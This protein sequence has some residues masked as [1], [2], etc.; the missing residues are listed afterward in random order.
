MIT[1]VWE[2]REWVF[3]GIGILLITVTMTIIKKGCHVVNMKRKEKQADKQGKGARHEE[4]YGETYEMRISGGNNNTQIGT[5]GTLN[6]IN[7]P[8]EDKS[9]ILARAMEKAIHDAEFGIRHIEENYIKT[10]NYREAEKQLEENNILILTGYP[11]MGKTEMAFALLYKFRYQFTIFSLEGVDE[12][13]EYLKIAD[14]KEELFFIDDLLGQ[15]IYRDSAEKTKRLREVIDNVLKSGGKKKLILTV[16]ETILKDF[17]QQNA[18]IKKLLD[19]NGVPMID[20]NFH[21]GE[22]KVDYISESMKR[23]KTGT[24]LKLDKEKVEFLCEKES[25]KTI[26]ESICFTP[27]AVNRLLRPQK[28]ISL[29]KYKKQFQSYMT[30][31]DFIWKKELD[32]LGEYCRL[33]LYIIY[34]LTDK[35]V[36][37]EIADRCF[38]ALIEED[39]NC[40]FSTQEAVESMNG[41]LINVQNEKGIQSIGLFH[42]TLNEY[43][44]EHIP[45]NLALRIVEHACYLDQLNRLE[46]FAKE[47]I[48]KKL[49][50]PHEFFTYGLVADEE[51]TF[52]AMMQETKPIIYG[53]YLLKYNIRDKGL[54]DIIIKIAKCMLQGNYFSLMKHEDIVVS[55]F[56]S[57]FYDMGIYLNDPQSFQKLL[58]ICSR[59]NM[60][61]LLEKRG[62]Y[63]NEF[64]D[65]RELAKKEPDVAEIVY[66]SLEEEAESAVIQE[67][68]EW[69]DD[70]LQKEDY[71]GMSEDE[72]I[73]QIGT[74]IWSSDNLAGVASQAFDAAAEEGR[75]KYCEYDVDDILGNALQNQL[76]DLI[77]EK[78]EET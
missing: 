7:H 26:A 8:S 75:I 48:K 53:K 20:V 78:I 43:I 63:K 77:L 25:L 47:L 14:D 29:E 31:A 49:F 35:M 32:A 69:L 46:K 24:D 58:S 74:D 40:E 6:V 44:G 23:A 41:V 64:I 45:D 1:R 52:H 10:E 60:S 76:Y 70:Y 38:R 56:L 4:K 39:K 37:L 21:S 11:L 62:Y 5:I 36:K 34:S 57:D 71:E 18:D 65:Y 33:Y 42:P 27:L 15:S 3:S 13:M 22:R 59:K 55:F 50:C 2:N 19:L 9:A 16:R 30:D 61:Q 17:L 66:R 51:D 68:E 12:L 54:E 67:L 28:D 72:I 73:E